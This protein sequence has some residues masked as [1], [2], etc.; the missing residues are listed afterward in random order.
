[1]YRRSRPMTGV[2]FCACKLAWLPGLSVL[3]LVFPR[4]A[5][6]SLDGL[7]RRSVTM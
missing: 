1:M 3:V 7:T 4:N 5:S 2:A 6:D